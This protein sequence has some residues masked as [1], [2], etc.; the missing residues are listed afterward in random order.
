MVYA[1]DPRIHRVWRTPDVLQFGIDRIRLQLDGVS[2]AEERMLAALDDGSTL[3]GIQLSAGRGVQLADVRRF[4]DRVAPVLAPERPRGT[5]AR[6]VI[7]GAGATAALLLRIL[8]EEGADVR[9]GLRWDDPFVESADAAIIV[10]RFALAPER[11]RRWLQHDIAHL[12]IVFGDEEVRVGPFVRPGRGPCLVCVD[13][14]RTD[15]DGD[16]PAIAS[17]LHTRP[18]M[19]ESELI[20]SLAGC[21]AAY[22]V[23]GALR[24]E[25][26]T[27]DREQSTAK[28]V[29]L[30]YATGR[31][32]ERTWWAHPL[33][34]CTGLS[35]L[36]PAD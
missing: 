10:G 25:A 20:A 26:S 16:W 23:L 19:Q 32:S 7:D 28:M 18:P 14:H 34:G 31:M 3:A 17:Q 13:L 30:D 35:E 12:P 1:L 6:I 15:E 29:S 22:T 2:T 24:S 36:G 11:H 33:C 5:R 4:L 9:S 8:A 27:P 21:A